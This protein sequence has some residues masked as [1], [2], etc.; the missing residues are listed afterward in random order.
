M[1]MLSVKILIAVYLSHISVFSY[2]NSRLCRESLMLLEYH[3]KI[4]NFVSISKNLRD[5]KK[6]WSTPICRPDG[7]VIAREHIPLT[8]VRIY[9]AHPSRYGNPLTK[10]G[11]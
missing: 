9:P 10:S 6:L 8:A 7:F 2:K 11:S 1:Q 4:G 5:I 3:Q